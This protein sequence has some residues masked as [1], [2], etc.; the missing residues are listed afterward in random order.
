MCFLFFVQRMIDKVGKLAMEARWRTDTAACFEKA[1][2]KSELEV[3]AM[4]DQVCD[5]FFF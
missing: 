3:A 4:R 5:E 1:L 2:K